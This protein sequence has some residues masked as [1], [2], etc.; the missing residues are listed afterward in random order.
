MTMDARSLS[1]EFATGGGAR[2]VT[3]MA[4]AVSA[5]IKRLAVEFPELNRPHSESPAGMAKV[6]LYVAGMAPRSR[7]A[8]ASLRSAM[9][10]HSGTPVEIVITD[11]LADPSAAVR[12]GLLAPPALVATQGD[13]VQSFVGDLREEQE[14]SDWFTSIATNLPARIASTTPG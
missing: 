9:R 5:T 13:V 8:M 2:H 11:V 1:T 7:A 6:E 4:Q 10:R 12:A 3:A 14:V